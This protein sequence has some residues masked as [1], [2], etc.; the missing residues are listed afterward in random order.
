MESK[1]QR[2]TEE[3]INTIY[4]NLC[5]YKTASAAARDMG[6]DISGLIK[7][8]KT[9]RILKVTTE[10]NKCSL[11]TTCKKKNDI[12][13]TC[14]YKSMYNQIKSC[15]GCKVNCNE[16]CP[17]FS[18]IPNCLA[19]KK[20]PY[21]CN[22]CPKKDHCHKNKYI[23]DSSLVWKA[24][25]NKRSESRK[26]S[27]ADERELLRLS[28]LLKPLILEKH[29]SLP[30]I[31]QSHKTEIRWSYV[32]ILS[33]IDQGLI[34]GIKN[35]DLTKR[36]RYPVSYKKKTYEPTNTAFIQNRTYDDFIDYISENP[37]DE[38][39]EMDTVLSS[40]NSNACLLTLLF[41]KSNYMMAFLLS[42][43]T[44]YNVKQVFL[45][46]RKALGEETFNNTFKVILT[47]NGSEFANPLDIEIDE[48]G[49]KT[50]R[51]FYCDPGKSGQKGKIEKNHV[52]LRKVFP[53]GTDFSIYSQTDI[54]IALCHI[55]SEP[56]GILNGNCPGI[57][58]PI[59]ISEKVT[60]IN[61]YQLINPDDVFLHPNLLKK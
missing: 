59:F 40:R 11:K 43:K 47:D 15:M 1:Y 36:V 29:Q 55:N 58:A 3:M 60:K 38:V 31:F 16:I 49:V 9:Y 39:I 52:E 17:D 44:S 26:G 30:Q 51:V 45:M 37:N 4:E 18:T 12:C 34:P 23:Y 61:H 10:R 57:I 27:H 19:L 56:R 21:V 46:L 25:V 20:W 54:D 24:L 32:T 7:H 22:G 50:T 35:I 42:N 2:Y 33:F 41:R 13:P 53:K 8:I 28:N 48:C 14:H 6:I 5:V